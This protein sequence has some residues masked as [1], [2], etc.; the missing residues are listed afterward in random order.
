MDNE[1]EREEGWGRSGNRTGQ[2][3]GGQGGGGTY[4]AAEVFRV[5]ACHEISIGE[6]IS[7]LFPSRT[8]RRGR[9]RGSSNAPRARHG[10]VEEVEEV[11]E[12]ENRAARKTLPPPPPRLSSPRERFRIG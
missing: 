2:E 1:R 6:V 12:N 8:P 9:R 7:L 10:E 11:E 4:Q 5:P 3:G